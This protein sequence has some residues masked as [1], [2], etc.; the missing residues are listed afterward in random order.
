MAVGENGKK[1]Q[2]YEEKYGEKSSFGVF[3]PKKNRG[4]I[5]CYV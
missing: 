5:Y 4:I 3:I 1:I 2:K